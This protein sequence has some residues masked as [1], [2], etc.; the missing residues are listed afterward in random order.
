MAHR[1]SCLSAEGDR[2]RN[3]FNRDTGPLEGER[4]KGGRFTRGVGIAG[5]TCLGG[6]RGTRNT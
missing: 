3:A 4:L 5:G 6:E 1:L 2:G